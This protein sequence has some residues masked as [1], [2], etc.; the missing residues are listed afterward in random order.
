MGDELCRVQQWWLAQG[1][2]I[3]LEVEEGL[4]YIAPHKSNCYLPTQVP[5]RSG[6]A[7]EIWPQGPGGSAHTESKPPDTIEIQGSNPGDLAHPEA[8][9]QVPRRPG[10]SREGAI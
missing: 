7:P 6:E 3:M 9:P 4:A 8:M 5:R 10:P 1:G 2:R